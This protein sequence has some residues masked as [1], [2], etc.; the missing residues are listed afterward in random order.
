[1]LLPGFRRSGG[2][3]VPESP[4]DGA[5]SRPG[6]RTLIHVAD[7][8]IS[9]LTNFAAAFLAAR[10]LSISELGAFGLGMLLYGLT[11][12]TTR[13]LSSDVFVLKAGSPAGGASAVVSAAL[14]ASAPISVLGLA[15]GTT[16]LPGVRLEWLWLTLPFLAV[17]DVTRFVAFRD[18]RPIVALA[19]DTAWGA[20]LLLLICLR[21]VPNTASSLLAV[22]A[23]TSIPGLLVA[24]ASLRIRLSISGGVR[25]IRS[26]W[27]TSR[28]LLGETSSRTAITLGTP[29]LLLA[30]SGQAE[31]GRLRAAQTLY[32]PATTL[33]LLAS[34]TLIVDLVDEHHRGPG[35]LDRRLLQL[36]GVLVV[37]CL[38]TA[39]AAKGIPRAVGVQLLG[40]NWQP[41]AE[42]ALPL[43][44]AYAMIAI[45]LVYTV[46]LR[47]IGKAKLAS[48]I[49]VLALLP[50]GSATAAG[51]WLGNGAGYSIGLASI[52][53]FT[54]LAAFAQFRRS[55]QAL[56]EPAAREGRCMVVGDDA[57]IGAVHNGA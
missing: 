17:Q 16:L 12:A 31:L 14:V 48:R 44:L 56:G 46:G 1:M 49:R 7:Q 36:S 28:S 39:A 41:A 55:D 24:L 8:A 42:L 57:A 27:P 35:A 51:S 22:W 4:A 33:F 21:G 13:A 20:S 53:T 9:S 40:S 45:G 26:A 18:G 25:W 37:A 32:A 6:R 50:T 3:R 23:F 43:G 54:A 38:A 34:S 15:A 30:L 52:S 10:A 5:Q 11:L 29:F 47:I 19:N 2:G